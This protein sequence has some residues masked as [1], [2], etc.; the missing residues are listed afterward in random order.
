MLPEPPISDVRG[1][2]RLFPFPF[3]PPNAPTDAPISPL[4]LICSSAVPPLPE[5]DCENDIWA[6][7]GPG[8][9]GGLAIG[10]ELME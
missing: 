9:V 6:D 5:L 4:L 3:T 7:F 10:A 8:E 2:G 1:D